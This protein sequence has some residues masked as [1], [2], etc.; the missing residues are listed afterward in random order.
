MDFVTVTEGVIAFKSGLD[1]IKTAINIIKD[2]KDN[3]SNS[4]DKDFISNA[5][6]QASQKMA[7]GEA[8]VAIALGYKLCRCTNPPNPMLLVGYIPIKNL[9]GMDKGQM[10]SRKTAIGG[11]LTGAIPVHE[12]PKCK[13]TDA[14][15]YPNFQRT[16]TN[17]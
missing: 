7:E 2:V 17:S 14:P 6:D 8:A 12:C 9:N 3:M 11:G 1:T 13:N 16:I 15:T 5:I 10:L 4:T